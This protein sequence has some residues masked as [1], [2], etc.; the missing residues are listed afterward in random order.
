MHYGA[1]AR[2]RVSLYGGTHARRV[3]GR[4][5]MGTLAPAHRSSILIVSHHTILYTRYPHSSTQHFK[6][7]RSIIDDI[8]VLICACFLCFIS[9]F[10][11]VPKNGVS[12]ECHQQSVIIDVSDLL[13]ILIFTIMNVLATK[14]GPKPSLQ[15]LCLPRVVRLVTWGGGSIFAEYHRAAAAVRFSPAAGLPPPDHILAHA[16]HTFTQGK[17]NF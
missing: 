11:S 14:T 16:G 2:A 8:K 12:G 5:T 10:I 17:P 9:L 1:G 13:S 6:E 15:V 4:H 3:G 7:N